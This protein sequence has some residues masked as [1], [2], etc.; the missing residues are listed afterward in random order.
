[1]RH[2]QSSQI[3]ISVSCT[4]G[5]GPSKLRRGR[6]SVLRGL[7]ATCSVLLLCGLASADGAFASPP[8]TALRYFYD[9]EGHLKAFYNPASETALYGWDEAGNLLTIGKKSSSVL[10]ITELA[11]AEAPVGETVTIDGTGFSTTASND[12]VKFNGRR[13]RCLLRRRG[14]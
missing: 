11:P 5:A 10:S 6:S 12:T 14:L 4:N 1:M 9:A 8:T 13:R 7:L 3:R 2:E